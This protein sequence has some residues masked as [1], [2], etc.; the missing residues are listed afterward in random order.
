MRF[1]FFHFIVMRPLFYL[2][3]RCL[4]FSIILASWCELEVRE[5]V[6]RIIKDI[7]NLVI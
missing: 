4:K 5:T 2:S 3:T 7:L 6:L 1:V